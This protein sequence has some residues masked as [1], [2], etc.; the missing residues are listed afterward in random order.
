MDNEQVKKHLKALDDAYAMLLS[1]TDDP[2]V[3]LFAQEFRDQ[4]QKAMLFFESIDGS[5]TPTSDAMRVGIPVIRRTP[6]GNAD[7]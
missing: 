4:N 2:L 6:G 1:S 7:A 5:K 3:S